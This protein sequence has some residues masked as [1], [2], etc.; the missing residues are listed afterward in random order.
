MLL[1]NEVIW[2]LELVD[3]ENLRTHL[4]TSALN[5]VAQWGLVTGPQLSKGFVVSCHSPQASVVCVIN[6]GSSPSP[7]HCLGFA[8]DYP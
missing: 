3:H 5:N 8:E 1:H 7:N 4:S 6:C 2:V